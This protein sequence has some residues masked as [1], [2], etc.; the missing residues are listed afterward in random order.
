MV[1]E[2]RKTGYFRVHR[3]II[4]GYDCGTA[5]DAP[6]KDMEVWKKDTEIPHPL[7]GTTVQSPPQGSLTHKLVC[8]F[9]GGFIMWVF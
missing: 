7:Q 2:L 8:G 4:N 3:F 6:G 5:R 1:T 9:Y